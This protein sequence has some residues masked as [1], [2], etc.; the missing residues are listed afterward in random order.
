LKLF[1]FVCLEEFSDRNQQ[2]AIYLRIG[3][4]QPKEGKGDGLA[5]AGLVTILLSYLYHKQTSSSPSHQSFRIEQKV[6]I[7]ETG[8]NN[9]TP[10]KKKEF[11]SK[12]EKMEKW[13]NGRGRLSLICN[14][15]QASVIM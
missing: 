6:M 15:Q 8:R 2:K 4:R 7:N 14:I 3:Q 5:A 1:L 10:T 9:Q 12:R 13:R 11:R